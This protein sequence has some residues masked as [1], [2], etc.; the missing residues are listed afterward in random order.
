MQLFKRSSSIR[1]TL[2]A[3]QAAEDEAAA[4]AAA[5]AQ[6]FENMHEDLDVVERQLAE[7]RERQEMLRSEPEAPK[8]PPQPAGNVTTLDLREIVELAGIED[9]DEDFDRRFGEFTAQSPDEQS[10][11]WL[12]QA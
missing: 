5:T 10:R 3:R 11:R 1:R 2:A 6:E 7:I 12:E 8:Q 4:K 9:A